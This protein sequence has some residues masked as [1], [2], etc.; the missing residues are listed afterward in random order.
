MATGREDAV[1]TIRA[2]GDELERLV[3]SAGK[4]AWSNEA[5]EGWTAKQLLCHIAS[6]SGVAGFVLVLARNPGMTPG[7]QLPSRSGG[8][9]DQVE[10]NAQQVAMR[11]ERPL[12]EVLEEIRGHLQGGIESVQAAPDELLGTHFRAPWEIEGTVAEVIAESVRGHLI[13]HL[14][15]LAAALA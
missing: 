2:A 8:G 1:R 13:M 9:F 6:T 14:R 7:Q 15:D 11:Q 4:G 3:H 5:Y 10:W 12:E